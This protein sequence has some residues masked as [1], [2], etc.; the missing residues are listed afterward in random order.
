MTNSKFDAAVATAA[1]A[2]A[3]A[4][5]RPAG[6]KGIALTPSARTIA[7][8]T[9]SYST[10]KVEIDRASRRATILIT[11]PTAPP[12]ASVT[13][14]HAQG[15]DFYPLRLARELDDA[16]LHLR[17]N[18]LATGTLV[19]KTAGDPAQVLAYDTL[20]AAHQGDWLVREILNYWKRVLKRVDV[21]SR[22]LV[23]LVEP[24]SCFAGTLAEIVFA[25][26]RAVMFFG[27]RT[28]QELPYFG[29]LQK[30]PATLLEQHLVFSR[31]PGADKEYVQDRIRAQGAAMAGLLADPATHIFIC[32]LKGMEAGVEEALADI[33]RARGLEWA[34]I[35]PDMRSQGRYHVETY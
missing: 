28:P 8:D 7:A 15:A 20:L 33:C 2:L 32:G 9:V 4:S 1:R 23:A 6:A 22:S 19:F 13:D 27:A 25:A 31:V 18:E 16:I 30:V 17:L 35:K 26:G 5:D 11:G 14:I 21:T 3:A 10:V 29:P 34:T 24:G 12:P